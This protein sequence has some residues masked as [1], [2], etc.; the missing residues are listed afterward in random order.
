[1]LLDGIQDDAGLTSLKNAIN[2]MKQI[3]MQHGSDNRSDLIA[4]LLS[5]IILNEFASILAL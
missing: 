5:N 4:Q 1:L 2:E 3:H